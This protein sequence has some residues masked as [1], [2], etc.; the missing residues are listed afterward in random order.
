MDFYRKFVQLLFLP[1][2]LKPFF[3]KEVGA[4]YGVGFSKKCKLLLQIYRIKRNV[5]TASSPYEHVQMVTEILKT[6]RAQ[7]GR[8]A[9]CGCYKGG[10]TCSLSLACSLTGRKL[11]IFDSFCGLPDPAPDD[12]VHHCPHI[13]KTPVYA[14]GDYSGSLEEVKNNIKKYGCIDVCEFVEGYYEQTMP[15]FAANF[16]GKFVFIFLDVDLRNSLE[17]CI[18][19]LWPFLQNG[20]MLFTHEAPHLEMSA[21]FFDQAWWRNNF[22]SNI[23]GL[24]GAGSGTAF[25]PSFG[26][27]IGYTI[28]SKI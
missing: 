3:K 4:E 1:I 16:K 6:P 18:R 5:Q 21:L 7:E 13:N 24:I 15:G 23:P 17:D 20:C 9:E 8:V 10:S 2:F 14:K 22:Q 11:I 27:P 25:H 26:T 19:F 28:K 12:K